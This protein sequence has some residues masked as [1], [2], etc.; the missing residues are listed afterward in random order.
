MRA[1]PLM[2]PTMVKSSGAI[3]GA[4]SEWVRHYNGCTECQK[5]DWYQPFPGALWFCEE[6][7]RL[8]RLWDNLTAGA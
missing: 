3:G 8:F 5:D 6:G 7:R 2:S 1:A 4:Y